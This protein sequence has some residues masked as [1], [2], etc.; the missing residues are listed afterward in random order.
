MQPAAA[1]ASK[2]MDDVWSIVVAYCSEVAP[3]HALCARLSAEGSCVVVI[4]NT[5]Q[6]SITAAQLPPGTRLVSLGA[7]TGIAHAQN[8]G[9]SVAVGGGAEVVVF[10][11]Q[12]STFEP[13]FLRALVA[14]LRRGSA[15]VVS[16]RCVDVDSRAEMPS[17][18]LA[19]FGRV[20]DVFCADASTPCQTDIVISSGT[21]ATAEAIALAGPLDED[22]FI[23]FVD[24]E[25]CLRCRSKRIPIR[26]VPQAVMFHRIGS[27]SI[28]QGNLTITIH[29]PVRCYYQVR[30]SLHLFRRQHVPWLFAA[31]EMAS[32][33][34]N[35]LLLL[36][37][38]NRRT[39]YL[40]AYA[41]GIRDGLLGVVGAKPTQ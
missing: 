25:W 16:P 22:F 20:E 28:A 40:I 39:D 19:T 37:H 32:V 8:V 21:A 11:D 27:R 33:L 5:E 10:F 3:L 36:R 18:R 24:T 9:V 4:D 17:Q 15:D 34:L 23:D 30:N 6:P 14:P 31:R 7:N 41:Q 13:G 26:V 35:R 38:V 12:D 2:L 1:T 29:S